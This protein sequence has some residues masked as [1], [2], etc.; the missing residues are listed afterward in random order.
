MYILQGEQNLH[1]KKSLVYKSEKN[2]N[3][4]LQPESYCNIYLH[5]FEVVGKGMSVG[6]KDTLDSN[7]TLHQLDCWTSRHFD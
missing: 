2:C 4:S 1:I 5:P 6:W 3:L 7:Q